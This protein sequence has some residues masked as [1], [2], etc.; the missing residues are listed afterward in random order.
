MCFL[1]FQ[2]NLKALNFGSVYL[3]G[4]ELALINN[5][6]LLDGKTYNKLI[7]Y[8]MQLKTRSHNILILKES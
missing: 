3:I 4:E 1:I 2:D 5:I 7:K 8:F 6:L